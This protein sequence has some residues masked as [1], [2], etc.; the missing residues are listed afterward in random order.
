M[1]MEHLSACPGM[2]STA[3]PMLVQQITGIF[4]WWE[5]NELSDLRMACMPGAVLVAMVE[6]VDGNVDLARD[7]EDAVVR[8]TG[9]SGFLWGRL[10]LT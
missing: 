9:D 7:G 5:R 4:S 2:E 6:C 3:Q 1:E 8:G 10:T